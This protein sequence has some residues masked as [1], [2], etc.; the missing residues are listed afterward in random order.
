MIHVI[1]GTMGS[2]KT[3]MLLSMYN[4]ETDLLLSVVSDGFVRSRN[5]Q[6][7]KPDNLFNFQ[8]WKKNRVLI[9]EFQFWSYSTVKDLVKFVEINNIDLIA[10]GLMVDCIGNTFRQTADLV[11]YA[12]VHTIKTTENG[13]KYP[14]FT[15]KTGYLN[16]TIEKKMDKKNYQNETPQN[17]WNV[18]DK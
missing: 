17:F 7:A 4:K 3:E 1:T 10:T 9:D 15:S 16:A 6:K 18:W 12:D 8:A 5:G 14:V 2:G 11:A 13:E